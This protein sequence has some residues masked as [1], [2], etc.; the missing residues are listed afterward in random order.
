MPKLREVNEKIPKDFESDSGS[1]TPVTSIE[2]HQFTPVED[3]T[4]HL[5]L[6][7]I[8]ILSEIHPQHFLEAQKKRC[9]EIKVLAGGRAEEDSFLLGR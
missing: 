3:L 5:I 8:T 1:K 6:P 9:S 4:W 7:L 2:L